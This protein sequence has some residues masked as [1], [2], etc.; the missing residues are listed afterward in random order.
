MR[1]ANATRSRSFRR[2]LAADRWVDPVSQPDRLDADRRPV[3]VDP[4]RMTGVV[5]DAAAPTVNPALTCPAAG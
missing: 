5:A 3:P 2:R 4:G 1:P